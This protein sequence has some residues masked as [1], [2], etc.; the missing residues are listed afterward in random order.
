M[1][2]HV[3]FV[4]TCFV[5]DEIL[6]VLFPSSYLLNDLLFIPN[7]GFC[8]IILTIRKFEFIDS[9]LFSFAFGMF[10]DFC[11]ANT[12]LLYA[13]IFAIVAA[14][15]QLWSKHMTDTLVESILLCISTIF[16]KDLIVYLYMNFQRLTGL[17]FMEWVERYELLTILANGIM[18]MIIVFLIRI[19]DD[20]LEM[21]AIRIRK[22][23]KIEWFK[24]KSKE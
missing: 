6:F 12:F 16:V 23:E 18:V 24:L 15:L 1:V 4:I 10:Y 3:L 8:A 22:G 20:Y 13:C 7:L 17:S 14:I 11:F 2:A 5:I 21:K 9:I 19:K